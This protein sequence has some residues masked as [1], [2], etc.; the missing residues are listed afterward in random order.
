MCSGSESITARSSWTR[1]QLSSSRG[2]GAHEEDSPHQRRHSTQRSG[3]G[4]RVSELRDTGSDF[5]GTGGDGG[6]PRFFHRSLSV[7][8][9]EPGRLRSLFEENLDLLLNI[10]SIPTCTGRASTGASHRSGGF[11]AAPTGEDSDLAGSGGTPESFARAGHG[12]AAD[13][14]VIGGETHRFRPLSISIGRREASR[15]SGRST[16]SRIAFVRIRG[17]IFGGSGGRLLS[18]I[19]ALVGTMGKERGWPPASRRQFDAQLGR[20]A[21][22][23]S[24]NQARW[25]RRS[26]AIARRLAGFRASRFKWIS[27]IY[28]MRS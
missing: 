12:S 28:R 16:Q 22:I 24:G 2:G 26:R 15:L 6:W 17:A 27:P 8:W 11:S 18:G 20:A 3:P 5:P 10:V 13:V 25:L 23:L 4:T 21:R 9:A 7:V 1:R 19:C 14:A